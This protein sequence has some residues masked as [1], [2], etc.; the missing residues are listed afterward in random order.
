MALQK[1]TI[2]SCID[3][4][5]HA[6]LVVAEDF[7]PEGLNRLEHHWCRRCGALTQVAFDHQDRPQVAS[8]KDGSPYLVTPKILDL[9][10]K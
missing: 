10:I 3:G 5:E 1:P 4:K 7:G 8:A 9:V 2:T 6:W